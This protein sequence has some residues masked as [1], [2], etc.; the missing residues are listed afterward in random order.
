MNPAMFA[1]GNSPV[2][3]RMQPKSPVVDEDEEGLEDTNASPTTPQ[4]TSSAVPHRLTSNPPMLDGF[5]RAAGPRPGDTVA[6]GEAIHWNFHSLEAIRVASGFLDTHLNDL[7][8]F[9]DRVVDHHTNLVRTLNL[10]RKTL[11]GVARA[12][13]TREQLNDLARGGVPGQENAD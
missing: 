12:A 9:H 7:A 3:S 6:L 10:V 2:R 1:F 5:I 11:D 13:Y 8:W 4:Q